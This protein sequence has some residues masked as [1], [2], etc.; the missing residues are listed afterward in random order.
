MICATASLSLQ[1]AGWH[2]EGR[3]R[4][5]WVGNSTSTQPGTRLCPEV[6]GAEQTEAA[7]AALQAALA[8]AYPVA[9]VV[10]P[11]LVGCALAGVWLDSVAWRLLY[12]VQ[13]VI[14]VVCA[15]LLALAA[16]SLQ[17][18]GGWA[19]V[20]SMPSSLWLAV[21]IEFLFSTF[22]LCCHSTARKA[23]AACFA[24]SMCCCFAGYIGY[25][26]VLLGREYW[27]AL[28][29]LPMPVVCYARM[30]SRK[31]YGMPTVNGLQVFPALLVGAYLDLFVCWVQAYSPFVHAVIRLSIQPFGSPF[32]LFAS[33]APALLLMSLT[34]PKYKALVPFKREDSQYADTAAAV[35]RRWEETVAAGD[36]D[37][38]GYGRCPS[39][40][41]SPAVLPEVLRDA[42]CAGSY[43][44]AL[45]VPQTRIVAVPPTRCSP[46][47]AS[48]QLWRW[49][50][51]TSTCRRMLLSWALPLTALRHCASWAYP[52][53]GLSTCACRLLRSSATAPHPTTGS[54][55]CSC[56]V[57][58]TLPRLR[59]VP[60]KFDTHTA[61]LGRPGRSL[62]SA[63]RQ[64]CAALPPGPRCIFAPCLRW[65]DLLLC[66]RHLPSASPSHR[67]MWTWW[68]AANLSP[69][70]Y[71]H[72]P[73]TWGRGQ[74]QHTTPRCGCA[75]LWWCLCV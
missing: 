72:V 12:V 59:D 16:P 29:M 54:S 55:W 14:G 17:G 65:M 44:I 13:A 22:Q 71:S 18:D 41:G 64:P 26:S 53:G 67:N 68:Q 39:L 70:R 15:V 5:T 2:D 28:P 38:S 60:R 62:P 35:Q 37:S 36:A 52:T 75:C 74:C 33:G 23:L 3:L 4:C 1:E 9:A 58:T 40:P 46:R 63:P 45:V 8:F 19:V 6:Q 43:R 30:C 61:L 57:P 50:P 25:C 56:C 24:L 42:Y 69:L 11:G 32:M 73:C 66:A 47:C 34:V 27:V 21:R 31:L 48:V 49:G 7:L 10:R 20:C 51:A